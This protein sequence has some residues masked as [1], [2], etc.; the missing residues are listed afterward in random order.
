M[1]RH[2]SLRTGRALLFASTLVAASISLF[3]WAHTVFGS[4]EDVGAKV[5]EIVHNMDTPNGN[6]LFNLS[7]QL[8]Q[9]G[10]K[11]I[12]FIKDNASHA[13]P[14][15]KVGCAKAL[16]TMKQSDEASGV[17]I[18][19]AKGGDDRELQI[20]AI[21]LL[22]SAKGDDVSSQLVDVLKNSYDPS[23]KVAA[24]KALWKSSPEKKFEAKEE[25]KKL[26]AS[27]SPENQFSGALALAAIGDI[28]SPTVKSLL[29]QLSNEP[30]ARGDLARSYIKQMDLQTV[31]DSK[32]SQLERQQDVISKLGKQQNP[33]ASKYQPGN[34]LDLLEEIM[35]DIRD[36]Y[37]RTNVTRDELITAAA[38]GMM[39]ALDPHSTFFSADEWARWMFE[40][41]PNYAGIGAYV[42]VRDDAFTITRPIY[43]G[44]AYKIGLRSG[45]A[46]L[47]VDGWPTEGKPVEEITNRLK[48]KPGTNVKIEVYRKGW[49]KARDFDI[50]RE[51][52]EI[53]TAKGEML[54]GDIGYTVLTTFASNT[55]KELEDV[56]KELEKK[57]LK[58][59]ILDLRYNSGGYL[60]EAVNIVS[61]FV[62]PGKLVVSC[63]GRDDQLY[64]DQEGKSQYYTRATGH[65]RTFPLVVLVNE[66]SASASEIVSGA[67]QDYKRA[68]IV[69]EKTYGKG[70]VQNPMQNL[71]TR[72]GEEFED[73]P[74]QDG[75]HEDDEPYTDVNHNGKY[76]LGEP[77]VDRP[78]LNGIWDRAEEY[79]D[80]NHNGQ[81]DPG[82][83]F[84]DSNNNGK[85]DP[86]EPYT[87]KNNNHKYD[88]GP[89]MKLTIARYFLPSGRSIH[90]EVDKDG[91]VLTDGGVVP[92]VPQKDDET[93]GWMIEEVQKIIESGAFDAY[94]EANWKGNEDLFVK[95]AVY[96]GGDPSL[97][98]NFDEWYQSLKTQ[99]PRDQVRKWLRRE[100]IQKRAAD[101]RGREFIEDFETDAVLQRGIVEVAKKAN[102]SL[103]SIAEFKAFVDRFKNAPADGEEKKTVRK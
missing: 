32:K 88:A 102:I 42:N 36:N 40:L 9:L 18:D 70:S 25:L 59:L 48:G 49:K 44:P 76:D 90:K 39:T 23:V 103:D 26:L 33:A 79:T 15:A 6:D 77:F 84:T 46:I 55:S 66:Y 21:N 28:E 12:P 98:P 1:T 14:R 3:G 54:P 63:K 57:D 94:A 61:K 67:L 74:R 34:D 60:R 71:D 87:D 7:A 75:I 38:K 97:Y 37:L 24:A 4:S 22:G 41:N 69:G 2:R 17:L 11:A 91:K 65:E 78:R 58:G 27:D 30:T 101:A 10:D 64:T 51:A 80:V 62:P 31:L 93:P 86:E 20:L 53:A 73:T 45:D 85:Y 81:W 99:A 96:D 82:E 89:G 72:P 52:I 8:E 19:V 29:Q 56:L 100:A 47:K 50:T 92:D 13:G 43:S 95:L 16:I 83:P 5:T 68:T 35:Q